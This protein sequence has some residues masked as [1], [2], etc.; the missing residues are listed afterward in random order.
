ML[1]YEYQESKTNTT[2]NAVKLSVSISLEEIIKIPT[3]KEYDLID[4]APLRTFEKQVTCMCY[5]SRHNICGNVANETANFIYSR[6]YPMHERYNNIFRGKD[7]QH[8][9][10]IN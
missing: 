6:F 9:Y 10:P 8:M 7:F 1:D 3:R 4:N 2:N 5:K